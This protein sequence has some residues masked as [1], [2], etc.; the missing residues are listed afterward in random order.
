MFAKSVINDI[1]IIP[2]IFGPEAVTFLSNDDKTRNPLDL[3]AA[4]LETPILMHLG[5]KVK[6]PNHS[7]VA[8]HVAK[9][10][11][12]NALI[13]SHNLIELFK[14]RDIPQ[15]PI[16][17]MEMG[18]AQDEAPWCPKPMHTAVY[19]FKEIKLDALICGVNAV[20][21]SLFNAIERRMAYLSHDFTD[22]IML[23]DQFGSHYAV[24][25]VAADA[26]LEKQNFLLS[27][28]ESLTTIWSRTV[29]DEH[30]VDARSMV[31]SHFQPTFD[32]SRNQAVGFYHQNI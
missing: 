29:I 10:D 14:C 13:H 4:T 20:G 32:L 25:G 26:E 30:D 27:V 11:T 16:L 28:A 22:V 18:A 1:F 8:T 31:L 2:K 6:L 9:H 24:N 15:K 3:D 17:L 7:F 23:H 19:L 5:Y 21:F 12:F